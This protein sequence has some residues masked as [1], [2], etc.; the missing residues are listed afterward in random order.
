MNEFL[1]WGEG[2]VAFLMLGVLAF[3]LLGVVLSDLSLDLLLPFLLLPG[4]YASVF[5]LSACRSVQY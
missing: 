1:S 2:L 5:V 4:D 3:L